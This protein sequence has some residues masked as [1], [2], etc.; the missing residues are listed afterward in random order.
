MDVNNKTHINA[1]G[2]VQPEKKEFNTSFVILGI[3]PFS[4][5]FTFDNILKI[6]Q[7]AENNTSEYR[8]FIPD[9]P[10]IYSLKSLGYESKKAE[11]KASKQI[12][13]LKNKCMSALKMVNRHTSQE[14]II[15]YSFLENNERFCR[16]L[17]QIIGLYS[18]CEDF[19]NACDEFSKVFLESKS[20]IPSKAAIRYS[21][22]YLVYEL[23]IFIC[24]N[25][26]FGTENASFMYPTCPKFVREILQ[27]KLSLDM[28]VD[29]EFIEY[30]I[31]N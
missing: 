28:K 26:I 5:K 12:R 20:I 22:M 15:D 1:N 6:V 13:Y 9:K 25:E 17:N 16:R 8:L 14:E 10:T 2:V 11:K 24:A 30:S 29:Q 27:N 18:K 23:P 7:W 19:G 21:S 3:S 4:S 31:R